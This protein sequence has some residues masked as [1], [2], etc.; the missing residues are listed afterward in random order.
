MEYTYIKKLETKDRYEVIILGG[1]TA[2][3]V[4]AIASARTGARTLLVERTGS[5]GGMM[6]TGNC[7]LTCYIIH[8]SN[9]SD[10]Y[11]VEDMLA[12]DPKSAQV[13]G[14]IPMEITSRLIKMNKAVATDGNAGSYVFT[15]MAAFKTLLNEMITDAGAEVLFHTSFVDTVMDGKTVKGVVL[16]NKEGLVLYEGMTFVDTTGDG[17][18]SVAAGAEYFLGIGEYDLVYKEDP[19]LLG[20]VGAMGVMF[21]IGSTDILKTLNYLKN[22]TE[23]PEF[24]VQIMSLQDYDTVVDC[25]KKQQMT[26][27]VI[28]GFSFGGLQIYNTPDPGIFVLGCPCIRG[29]GINPKDK[30]RAE[31]EMSAMIDSWMDEIRRVPGFENSTVLDIPEIGVRETRH[32]IGEHVLGLKEILN[33]H[34]FEDSIGKGSHLIDI[35]PVPSWLKKDELPEMFEFTIPYR[36]LVVK[37]VDNMFV[38]G[39]SMSATHEA[40]GTIR[41]TVQCMV[42]GEAAGTAA[43]MCSG[44]GGSSRSIP[45]KEIRKKLLENG[46]IL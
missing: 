10:Q 31:L 15:E 1:G 19:S 30:S 33:M 34:N 4:A 18:A 45:Y 39:R 20:K 8:A 24:E 17:D 5:L 14:G 9:I 13:I 44:N 3:V 28:S 43:A 16:H 37:N 7:G 21:R 6:T 2:G 38:A 26:T 40:S 32:I 22:R 12:K 23:A 35:S 46:V 29:N 11:K 25:I 41:V 42:T 36:S 27:F